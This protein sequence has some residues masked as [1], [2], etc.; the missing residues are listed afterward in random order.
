[1]EKKKERFGI[2]LGILALAIISR[3]DAIMAPSIAEIKHSFPTVPP[4]QVES[5]VSIGGS[6]AVVSALLFGKLL[7]KWAYKTVALIGISCVAFGGLMPLLF[8]NTVSILLFF[9][10]IAGFGV[11]TITT[12]LPSLAAHF[13]KGERLSSLLGKIIAI[14]DGSSMI[15]MYVG[16]RLALQSWVHNYYLYALSFV[17]LVFVL[18]FV[19]FEKAMPSNEKENANANTSIHQKQHTL[20]IVWCLLLGFFN[21]FLVAVMYNKLA[22]YI[23]TYHLGGPD[24]AGKALMFNTGSSIVVGLLINPIKKRLKDHTLAFGYF[25]M[26]VGATLFLTLPYF[27]IVCLAAFLIGSGSAIAMISLPYMLSNLAQHDKYPFVMGMF[28]AITSL[29]FTSSTFVFNTFAQAFHL[30]PLRSTFI[31]M[32]SIALLLSLLLLVTQFQKKV[33]RYYLE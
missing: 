32:L 7:Q 20:P 22:I 6:A 30:D 10:V 1:M 18:L 4:F 16:G 27:Y 2:L 14:Q 24:M 3:F 25:L 15:L 5:I 28:S 31:G 23:D 26:V 29:G 13:F 9:A 33:Q 11:G 8:H 19:P 17:A 12:V 21:I